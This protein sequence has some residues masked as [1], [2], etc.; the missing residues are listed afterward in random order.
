MNNQLEIVRADLSHVNFLSDF[1]KGSFIDAYKLTLPIEELRAYVDEAFSEELIRHE[2]E[3][4]EA[5]YLICRNAKSIMCGYAKFV[6]S[7][8]PDCVVDYE[9]IELQRL[10][11]RNEYRGNGV[12]GLLYRYG[13]S[14][15]QQNGSGVVWLHVWDGNTIARK[16]YLKWGFT[17]CGEGT[18]K[19][20]REE[21][22]VLIMMKYI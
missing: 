6:N 1:G 5:L 13:E 16:I 19:V 20:G 3:S 22:K 9:A 11:V 7:E 21:R 14:L 12:G 17:I 10:Y 18:Y 2:I 15:S 4:S 8:I